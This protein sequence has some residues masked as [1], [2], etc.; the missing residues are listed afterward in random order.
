VLARIDT[1]SADLTGQLAAAHM[2]AHSPVLLDMPTEAQ[3]FVKRLARYTNAAV[4]LVRTFVYIATLHK[5]RAGSLFEVEAV[6]ATGRGSVL[7]S[8][9]DSGTEPESFE[10]YLRTSFALGLKSLLARK[11]DQVRD[12]WKTARA[13]KTL[14]LHAEL[15]LALFYMQNP[16]SC[17]IGGFIG[18][19]KKCCYLCDFT[20][21]CVKPFITM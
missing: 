3:S 7:T 11:V 1:N 21:K 9:A 18:V 4:T 14:F 8:A 2:L 6:N 17:P 13:H 16:L 12:S 10:G 20:I 19:S 5:Q 15:Q